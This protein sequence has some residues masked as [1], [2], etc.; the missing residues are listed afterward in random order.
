MNWFFFL[1]LLKGGL[2]L[3][4]L[5]PDAC[6][7]MLC[8]VGSSTLL[9]NKLDHVYL[10]IICSNFFIYSF[11]FEFNFFF[12]YLIW[13]ALWNIGCNSNSNNQKKKKKKL[14]IIIIISQTSHSF[15][16]SFIHLFIEWI[17]CCNI[18]Y[19]IY[20]EMVFYNWKKIYKFLIEK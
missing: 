11:L 15:I 12:S 14:K 9:A 16:Y 4:C 2:C 7:C 20:V 8:F 17:A 18:S 6:A 10:S 3:Y 13:F 1:F 19:I 5:L